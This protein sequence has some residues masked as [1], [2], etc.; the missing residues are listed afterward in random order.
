MNY[1]TCTDDSFIDMLAILVYN[2]LMS[3]NQ[4]PQDNS[5][6]PPIQMPGDKPAAAEQISTSMIDFAKVLVLRGKLVKILMPPHT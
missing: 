1:T 3:H 2:I 5:D 4:Y 6:E